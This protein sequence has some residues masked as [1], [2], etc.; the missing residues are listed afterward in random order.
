[1]ALRLAGIT[2][3]TPDPPG[4]VSVRDAQG[5]P[6][7]ILKDAATEYI[8]RVIPPMSHEQCLRTIRQAL[9]HAAS[10]GVT[11]IQDMNEEYSDGYADIE[12]YS[13]L[14]EQGELTARVYVAP[15]IS[16]WQDQ[17]KIGL[18][19]GFGSS[20]LRVGALKGFADGSL[21]SRTAYCFEPLHDDPSNRGFLRAQMR[22]LSAMRQRM[23]RADAS[24][25]Q[26][27]LHAWR[28]GNFHG[29]GFVL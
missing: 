5:N 6:T 12:A 23:M 18:R 1:V 20:Y 13:E 9:A 24:G 29:A 8:N 3:Q 4:G 19:H 28:P 15:S 21:G 2:A 26:V 16:D 7:G 25:L 14:L 10:L 27:C 22:P 11:S 17:A